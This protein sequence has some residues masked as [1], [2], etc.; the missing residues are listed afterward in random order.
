M[1]E[2]R[3]VTPFIEKLRS[4]LRGRKV[5][6]QLRYADL[7]SARTQPPPEIPGGPY[8]KISKIYYYTHDARREVEPP[9]EIF[10]D[11][12]ITAGSEK[13][14][15]GPSHTTPGKLFPWS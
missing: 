6:P 12:Q 9:V 4:F 2:H 10:V 11:K 1:A 5:I 15:I 3:A 8:H 7:T 13:K 14:A